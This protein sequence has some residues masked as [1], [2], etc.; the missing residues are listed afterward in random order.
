[1]VYDLLGLHFTN[2]IGI[3]RENRTLPFSSQPGL[4]LLLF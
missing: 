3:E 1:M 2:T 4:L